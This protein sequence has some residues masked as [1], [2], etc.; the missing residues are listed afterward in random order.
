M[1]KRMMNIAAFILSAVLLI[2]GILGSQ[3]SEVFQKAVK[4]C[5]ECV[6]IG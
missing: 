1:K 6:G 3:Y 4:I 2:I 5:M